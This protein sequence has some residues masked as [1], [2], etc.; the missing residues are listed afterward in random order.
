MYNNIIILYN[1]KLINRFTCYELFGRIL[2]F[3]A[4]VITLSCTT[5]QLCLH[6]K[7]I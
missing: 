6:I 1:L 3:L 5:S 7:I 4:T 2:R